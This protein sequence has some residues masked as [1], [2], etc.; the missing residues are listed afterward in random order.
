MQ[1]RTAAK[2]LTHDYFTKDPKPEPLF[3]LKD[4]QGEWHEFETKK[5]RRKE[6]KR[7]Q[8][9]QDRLK[10]QESNNTDNP[11]DQQNGQESV[12]Y[13]SGLTVDNQPGEPSESHARST[14]NDDTTGPAVDTPMPP[15]A[16]PAEAEEL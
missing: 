15:S 6:R 1:A 10:S 9:E 2:A 13:Q 16:P 12:S 14:N 3:F 8:D 4:V 11:T 5:R 7:I